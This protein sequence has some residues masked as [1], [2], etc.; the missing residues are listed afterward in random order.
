MLRFTWGCMGFYLHVGT[1][2]R[3]GAVT[4]SHRE[5][6]GERMDGLRNGPWWDGKPKSKTLLCL[7]NRFGSE[8]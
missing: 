2:V 7:I 3:R 1:T 4:T 6:G 8:V 5:S